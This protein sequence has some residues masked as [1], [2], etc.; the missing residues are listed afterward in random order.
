MA[1]TTTEHVTALAPANDNASDTTSTS[2]RSL[3]KRKGEEIPPPEPKRQLT[4]FERLKATKCQLDAGHAEPLLKTLTLDQWQV[5]ARLPVTDAYQ[6]LVQ[7]LVQHHPDGRENELWKYHRK[8]WGFMQRMTGSCVAKTFGVAYFRE[9]KFKFLRELLWYPFQ[10]TE[11]CLYGT[12]NEPRA[13]ELFMRFQRTFIGEKTADGWELVDV[14]VHNF[15]C[16]VVRS[17]P[18]LAMSPDGVLLKKYMGPDGRTRTV[19]ELVEY[20]CPWK[21]RNDTKVGHANLY[22]SHPVKKTDLTLPIPSSYYAQVQH[23]MRCMGVHEDYLTNLVAHFVVWSPAHTKPGQPVFRARN[24]QDTST[25]FADEGGL[26]QHTVIPY[27]EPYA[28][29]LE[30]AATSFFFDDYLPVLYKK[31]QGELEVGEVSSSDLIS[32]LE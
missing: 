3:G 32:L 19:R 22:P 14:S 27:N 7:K 23:G 24:Y 11:A 1:T 16:C 18:W 5:L 9:T 31:T 15:G 6:K 17:K 30:A 2:Q 26:L 12:K 28:T 25:L 29:Q 13:Q 21:R 8:L 20:K 4:P 10:S